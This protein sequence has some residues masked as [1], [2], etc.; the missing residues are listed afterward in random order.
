MSQSLREVSKETSCQGVDFFA[1]ESDGVGVLEECFEKFCRLVA[2]SREGEGLD[3]PE[4]A[5]Q[6]GPFL[7]REP[8][9]ARGVPVQEGKAG[10]ELFADRIHCSFNSV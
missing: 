10:R 4:G 1:V 5:G 6:E 9:L 8:V 3:E 7:S 2:S